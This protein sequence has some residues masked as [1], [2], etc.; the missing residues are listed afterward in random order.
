M[1]G[2]GDDVGVILRDAHLLKY[3]P[4]HPCP[5]RLDLG[6]LLGTV[7]RLHPVRESRCPV[8]VGG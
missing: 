5:G 2:E 6:R 3:I 4:R 8:E 7:W 1:G